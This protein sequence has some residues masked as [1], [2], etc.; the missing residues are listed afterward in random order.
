ML[1]KFATLVVSRIDIV[2]IVHNFLLTSD[3]VM[4]GIFNA[5]CY[6]A[7]SHSIALSKCEVKPLDS[8]EVRV[9]NLCFG[10]NPVDWKFI[11]SNPLV[12]PNGHIP[13]VDGVG[14]IVEVADDVDKSLAG[15]R[16]AYHQSLV[17]LGSFAEQTVLRAERVMQVPLVITDAVAASLPCPMLTAWQA[18][19][20]IP[21]DKAEH[22]LVIGVGAVNKILIQLLVK[23]NMMVDVVSKSISKDDAK[24]LGVSNVFREQGRL[25]A[26]YFAAFDA[27]GSLSASQYVN[28]LQA[29]GHIICIQDRIESPIDPPFTKTISYHEIALGALH[30]YGDARAWRD[31]MAAGENMMADIAGGKIDIET[32]VIF[33]FDECLDALKHSKYSKLKTVVA[34]P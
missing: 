3:K 7:T 13:G 34:L 8:G 15:K 14:V 32:P 27:V 20:K 6:D 25:E 28:N 5:W 4:Q 24:S 2:V 16:V 11:E 23:A 19:R 26:S 33:A 18:F 31:L 22:V 9:K 10:I 12:W 30:Q 1:A 17:Q 21:T 29:N